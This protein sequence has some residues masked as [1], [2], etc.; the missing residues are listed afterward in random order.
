MKNAILVILVLVAA[1]LV[2]VQSRPDRYRIERSTTIHASADTVFAH[3]N[4][5]H[6]W[7]A[8]SPWE[9][10]DP[11]MQRT[12]AGSPSGVGATY[13]WSGNN[14]AGA[15]SMAI[16]QSRPGSLVAINMEFLRPMKDSS[17]ITFTLSSEGGETKVNWALEGRMPFISKAVCVFMSMDK[18]VG[19]DFER[20]LANLKRVSESAA[21]AGTPAAA[22]TTK[23][24][25]PGGMSVK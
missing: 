18:M 17:V 1:F 21:S 3:I 15:G 12:I 10:L 25:A 14:K 20:G 13:S 22:D 24:A 6:R 16:A 2:F 11:Q 19:P 8:W 23:P 5:F 7:L 4:D 9:K